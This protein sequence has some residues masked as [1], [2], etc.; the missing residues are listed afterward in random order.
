MEQAGHSDHY[1][2]GQLAAE[3]GLNPKT[4]RYYEELGLLPPAAR[5]L[6]GYRLYTVVER[7]WLRFIIKAKATGL[8][9]A[10]IGDILA[11]RRDGQEPCAHIGAM[12]DR[13]LAVVEAQLRALTEVRDE[14]LALRAEAATG[15]CGGDVCGIIERHAPRRRPAPVPTV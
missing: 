11:L 13:K 9:L 2:I 14:L 15:A 1:R 6:A 10:E 4:I 5:T 3:L 8:T 12:L 7:D